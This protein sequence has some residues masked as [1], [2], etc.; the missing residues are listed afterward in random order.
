M[1]QEDHAEPPGK[2]WCIFGQ[3]SPATL[4]GGVAQWVCAVLEKDGRFD[5]GLSQFTL[6]FVQLGHYVPAHVGGGVV[7][8]DGSDGQH[9]S[10]EAY[11]S[12]LPKRRFERQKR[13]LTMTLRGDP[14]LDF[15]DPYG[16]AD[17]SVAQLRIGAVMV[18]R[19]LEYAQS[20]FKPRDGVDISPIIRCAATLAGRDWPSDDAMRQ[21]L[22]EAYGLDRA[23]IDAMDPWAKI[24]LS[25]SHVDARKILDQPSDWSAFDDLSPH[26]NDL[27]ADILGG[28]S[29]LKAKSIPEIGK[30]FEL[31]VI[32][33]D[34]DASMARIQVML[35]LAFGHIKK[36]G[37]CPRELAMKTLETLRADEKRAADMV[38]ADH[39]DN[40]KAAC[41]RYIS[42][43]KTITIQ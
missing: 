40:W 21:E 23:R 25:G 17:L 12:Q 33:D 41:A 2:T 1:T 31:D 32:S 6:T 16:L 9:E 10:W 37:D 42:I 11:L 18:L 26:G 29:R 14:G 27:G 24:D 7:I 39:L 20:T 30:Y 19:A 13:R 3:H 35:A 15:L 8:R 22:T 4:G 38:V 36:H 5:T 28:W 34:A 43:L